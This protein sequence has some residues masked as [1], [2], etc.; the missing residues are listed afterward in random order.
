MR[1][2]TPRHIKKNKNR[3]LDRRFPKFDALEAE[4]FSAS[5]H[6]RKKLR[7]LPQQSRADD[8]AAQYPNYISEERRPPPNREE[9]EPP[10]LWVD[11]EDTEIMQFSVHALLTYVLWMTSWHTRPD[12]R[13]PQQ[14]PERLLLIVLRR[15]IEKYGDFEAHG[16]ASEGDFVARVRT[17]LLYMAHSGVLRVLQ[18]VVQQGRPQEPLYEISPRVAEEL[19]QQMHSTAPEN[20]ARP[21]WRLHWATVQN[22][23]HLAEPN[24]LS[25][26]EQPPRAPPSPP[27][28]LVVEESDSDDSDDSDD[29]H[30]RHQLPLPAAAEAPRGPVSLSNFDRINEIV[31]REMARASAR[32]ATPSVVRRARFEELEEPPRPDPKMAAAMGRYPSPPP[33]PRG[34][35]DPLD[36]FETGSE[37]YVPLGPGQED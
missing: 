3:K 15:F 12:F 25:T 5:L 31:S 8:V 11:A 9:A 17:S 26:P 32:D 33:S 21:E 19:D 35:F 30:A 18:E 27:D 6:E 36:F 2:T 10:P 23:L 24:V 16:S 28:L 14:V 22:K 20:M 13:T 34:R 29:D 37:E 7:V 1:A 4:M